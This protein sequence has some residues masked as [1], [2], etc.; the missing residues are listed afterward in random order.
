MDLLEPPTLVHT[1]EKTLSK[2]K[3]MSEISKETASDKK[4][5]TPAKKNWLTKLQNDADKLRIGSREPWTAGFPS[6]GV[7]YLFGKAQ[8]ML[9]GYTALFYGPPKSGKSLL[10]FAAAGQLHKDDPEA[11]V[12]HFDTEYRDNVD[13][14]VKSFGIDEKRFVTKQ[15][16]NPLDIFDY[17]ANDV[18]AM[19]Q[20]GAPIKMIIIDSLAMI[21]YPK[22]A[23]KE[24]STDFI[25]GDAGSYL[26]P[27]MKMIIPVIRQFKIATIL[28]QH[29]RANMNPNEAKYRP[30]I[31]P[32]GFALKH[33]VEYW[34]LAA[35]IES[36]DAKTFDS[37]RKDGSGNDIQTG[38]AIRIKMEENS[39]GPQNRSVEVDLD[40]Q[41]GLVNQHMEVATLA[42]NMGI[43]QMNG[44]WVMYGD[45][46][47]QG[48]SNFA[49]FVKADEELQRELIK[50]IKDNDLT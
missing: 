45:K 32:G 24:N 49:L 20:E 39:L 15:S 4:E 3:D 17:I 11:I 43:V 50:K 16:N 12:L 21:Q 40:Y 1:L 2:G 14:W 37:G 6:P 38:H 42:V 28:C 19:L 10:A 7:N 44:A 9:A 29:V 25:I 47:W 33:C 23:N 48:V 27:A 13:T 18:K 46:K 30:Y 22:E 34:M 31:I 41:Q 36:K 35:K 8:G 5:K 26:G